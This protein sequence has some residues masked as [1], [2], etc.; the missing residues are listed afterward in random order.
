M[1]SKIRRTGGIIYIIYIAHGYRENTLISCT[2]F[3]FYAIPVRVGRSQIGFSDYFL[4][5]PIQRQ[6]RI[7]GCRRRRYVKDRVFTKSEDQFLQLP[8]VAGVLPMHH[9]ESVSLSPDGERLTCTTKRA[10]L[11]WAPLTSQDYDHDDGS[12][13]RCHGRSTKRKWTPTVSNKNPFSDCTRTSA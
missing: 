7:F 8:E 6:Y 3:R 13:V 9:V 12:S 1:C 11:Y 4:P 10:Q 5:N 2:P